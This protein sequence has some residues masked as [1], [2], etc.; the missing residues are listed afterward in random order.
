M[1]NIALYT[2]LHNASLYLYNDSRSVVSSPMLVTMDLISVCNKFNLERLSFKTCCR[3]SICMDAC[4]ITS[5]TMPFIKIFLTIRH[6]AIIIMV[7]SDTIR[8]YAKDFEPKNPQLA[9][10]IRRVADIMD[11]PI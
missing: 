8:S 1:S 11:E 9:K 6:A 10:I 4:R 5:A 7:D 2:G 3:F